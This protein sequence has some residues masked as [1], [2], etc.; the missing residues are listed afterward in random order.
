MRRSTSR[1]R[2]LS[3]TTIVAVASVLAVGTVAAAAKFDLG[4]GVERDQELAKN[5]E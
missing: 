3:T 2:R 4:F 1:T 5:S